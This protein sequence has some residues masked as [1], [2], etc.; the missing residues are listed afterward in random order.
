MIEEASNESAFYSIGAL[1]IT[2]GLPV[3]CYTIAF[4]C[5]DVSGCPAPSLLSPSTL[6]IAKLKEEVAWPG[7]TG[8]LNSKAMGVTLA[9]YLTSLITYRFLP[10]KEVEGTELKQGGRILYRLNG[11]VHEVCLSE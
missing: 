8:L 9:Y 7:F 1:G 2:F 4:L 6:K 11:M 3:L 10:A 5:N